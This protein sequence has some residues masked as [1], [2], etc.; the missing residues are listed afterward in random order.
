MRHHLHDS[1][2]VA[3]RRYAGAWTALSRCCD[4]LAERRATRAPAGFG[5]GR[6]VREP[7][8][9]GAQ[10]LGRASHRLGQTARRGRNAY[11]SL[12]V[13][14]LG[15]ASVA[16]HGPRQPGGIGMCYSAGRC[17]TMSHGGAEAWA[18][19]GRGRSQCGCV[20]TLGATGMF[21]KADAP[22]SCTWRRRAEARSHCEGA[23]LHESSAASWHIR[24]TRVG[25][26]P[27]S[28]QLFADRRR[29]KREPAHLRRGKVGGFDC[30]SL[31]GPNTAPP[32]CSP[33]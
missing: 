25:M 23:K 18:T 33:F 6:A 24:C 3:V 11:P 21:F 26:L 2:R 28:D 29:P 12:L 27:I 20:W 22:R 30:A 32:T 4:A 1:R 15:R 10:R 14:A 9:V 17:S 31:L 13:S 8:Q 5:L 16:A 19:G 7:W